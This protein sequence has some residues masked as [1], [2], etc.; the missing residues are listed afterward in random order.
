[1]V[2]VASQF[3]ILFTLLPFAQASEV[4]CDDNFVMMTDK[5]HY[6]V[7]ET[8]EISGCVTAE[9]V[10]EDLLVTIQ[11]FESKLLSKLISPDPNGKFSLQ[12]TIDENYSFSGYAIRGTSGLENFGT[13]F[14]VSQ[15]ADM[16]ATVSE[17]NPILLFTDRENYENEDIMQVYGC[18][19]ESAF[20]KGI[21]IGVFD[22]DGNLVER[23]TFVPNPDRTFSDEIVIDNKFD[24]DGTYTVEVDAAGLY[25]TSKTVIIPE[26]GAMTIT[27][28]SLS[29]ISTIFFARKFMSNRF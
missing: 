12:V 6:S 22:P 17:D 2:I 4:T 20:T 23:T 8:V 14:V 19:A 18:L 29:L 15:F 16:C 7:G 28:L 25:I 11:N 3:L 26:F 24:V 1:M 5:F 10:N 27:V 13:S 9:N 21:N